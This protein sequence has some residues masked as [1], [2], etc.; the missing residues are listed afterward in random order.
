MTFFLNPYFGNCLFG[1]SA[2][3][4]K[5]CTY[6][7][8]LIE[9]K[10][11]ERGKYHGNIFWE[12]RLIFPELLVTWNK[13]PSHNIS[14]LLFTYSALLLKSW[15]T[16]CIQNYFNF[17]FHSPHMAS[18]RII[19]PFPPYDPFAHK[20]A[21]GF[22]QPSPP[23]RTLTMAIDFSEALDM[24]NHIKLFIHKRA[25]SQLLIL[26][27]LV[28]LSRRI[29]IPHGSYISPALFNFFASE[30]SQS[31]NL[32]ANSYADDFTNSWNDWSLYHPSWADDRGLTISDQNSTITLFSSQ[33]SQSTIQPH[34][35]LYNSL[36]LLER[37]PRIL[38]ATS[39]LLFTFR[40]RVDSIATQA[41]SRINILRALASTNWGQQKETI[42]ITYKSLIRP[43]VS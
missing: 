37:T 28:L 23:H 4:Y 42:L 39:D 6:I 11:L 16:F 3:F 19:P 33:K 5:K 15:N 1:G 2:Q 29:G 13:S 21:W 9:I 17:L 30:F 31:D 35:T 22:N 27:T 32:L 20:I 38:G 14:L 25:D 7:Q 12:T 43:L 34:F 26:Y 36:L 10:Q 40:T 8:N 18:I 41:S 24:V